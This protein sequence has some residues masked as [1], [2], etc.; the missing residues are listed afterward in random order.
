MLMG[1]LK[2]KTHTRVGISFFKNWASIPFFFN[3]FHFF[4]C[5]LM[6]LTILHAKR[7]SKEVFM[8]GEFH[9]QAYHAKCNPFSRLAK[10]VC[11][12][13]VFSMH[14]KGSLSLTS[15]HPFSLSQELTLVKPFKVVPYPTPIHFL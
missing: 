12:L 3:A 4:V 2:I 8:L 15:F 14:G 6:L 10:W 5:S 7:K 11:T 1:N 9:V 13:K